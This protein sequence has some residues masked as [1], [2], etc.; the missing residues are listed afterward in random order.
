M[1]LGVGGGARPAVALRGRRHLGSARKRLR[2]RVLSDNRG[3]IYNL[4]SPRQTADAM[5]F[6]DM[7]SYYARWVPEK[8]A[9]ILAER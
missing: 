1:G 3:S 4:D 5:N 2:L 9:I 7:I 8:P 6:V